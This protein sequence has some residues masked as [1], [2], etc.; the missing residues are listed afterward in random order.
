PAVASAPSSPSPSGAT[1]SMPVRNPAP[2][3]APRGGAARAARDTAAPRP[4]RP[5]VRS[6]EVVAPS[7]DSARASARDAALSVLDPKPQAALELTQLERPSP[8]GELD[9]MWRTMSWDGA[10]AEAGERLP[11]IDGLP[12]VQ[13]QVQSGEQ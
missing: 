8:S 3:P 13:V 11:H 9:G 10:K 12:V 1:A 4:A 5:A 2:K 7:S 6:V